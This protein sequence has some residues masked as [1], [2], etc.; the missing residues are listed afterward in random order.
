MKSLSESLLLLL[1]IGMLCGGAFFTVS[2]GDGRLESVRTP[3]EAQ[4]ENSMYHTAESKRVYESLLLDDME[5][6]SGWSV[7]G[8]A[9]IS[10]TAD[11]A[12]DPVFPEGNRALHDGKVSARLDGIQQ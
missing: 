12:K 3:M 2:A 4:Y 9:K 7:E 11:R 1:T 5:D 10:Y 8:I 6:P